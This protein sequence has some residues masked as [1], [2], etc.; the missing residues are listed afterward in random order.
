MARATNR[1]TSVLG[2]AIAIVLI[3]GSPVFAGQE[4]IRR[5]LT[6]AERLYHNLDNERALEQVQRAKQYASGLED[7]VLVALYE[8][9]ILSDLGRADDAMAAFR[10][11]LLLKPTAKLPMKV[12]PK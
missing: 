4:D 2:A 10:T 11:A 12:S 1:W 3:G 6:A 8:G 9:T 5:Y 7:D